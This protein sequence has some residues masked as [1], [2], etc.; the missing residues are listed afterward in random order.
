MFR[1]NVNSVILKNKCIKIRFELKLACIALKPFV[2]RKSNIIIKG[3]IYRHRVIVFSGLKK[4][5]IE[6]VFR[7]PNIHSE[8]DTIKCQKFILDTYSL[9]LVFLYL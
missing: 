8:N 3:I 1:Y 7:R 9:Q 2:W 5:L 6:T 4:K